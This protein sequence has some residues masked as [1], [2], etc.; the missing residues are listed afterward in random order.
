MKLYYIIIWAFT[1]VSLSP[2]SGKPVAVTN[3]IV[4][5]S[6]SF[7]I[8]LYTHLASEPGNLVLSPFSV[9]TVLA[10]T[11]SGAKS[12]TAQQMA[13]TLFFKN[14]DT[15]VH[16]F[17]STLLKQLNRTNVFDSQFISANSLWARQGYSF[18][19]PFT[20]L[21][22]NQYGAAITPIDLTGPT[23]DF[24]QA[25][26]EAARKR[27]DL[28]VE[29]HTASRIKK[30]LPDTLPDAATRFILLNATYF[31]GA[32]EIPF[33]KKLTEYY[34]FHI[35]AVE[36]VSVPI[37]YVKG[38]FGF[39]QNS[40]F[41]FL[42]MSYIS[43]HFSMMVLLPTG[44]DG[45]AELEKKLT[46]QLVERLRQE[47]KMREI[48]AYMPR[49]KASSRYNL[50]EPLQNMGMRDAFSEVK[51]DFSGITQQKPIYIEDVIHRAYVEVNEEGTE[52]AAAS[53]AI[54]TQGIMDVF[55]A[56]HPFLFMIIDNPTGTIL[57]IGRVTNPL[58]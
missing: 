58:D 18:L 11:Y 23:G 7:T 10:M 50:K 33:D 36:S 34:P 45:L 8:N 27:I 38:R 21:L 39:Y 24:D 1:T 2:L 56:N 53:I 15:N 32:W 25:K 6:N 42:E 49:F 5:A 19:S 12:E 47:S 54:G 22:E 52:A 51:A 40:D 43:N 14:G 9:E 16:T 44:K 57:F 55:N 37:M 31:K 20:K 41:Q 4:K 26:A 28:W 29:G 17:F 3:E 35:S 30:A 48:K 46:G 13:D